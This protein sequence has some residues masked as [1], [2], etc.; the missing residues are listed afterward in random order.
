MEN[1]KS[2]TPHSCHEKRDFRLLF[3]FLLSK[4][5]SG[6]KKST[7][8]NGNSH[9]IRKRHFPKTENLSA[10]HELLS[11]E[12]ESFPHVDK[13]RDCKAGIFLRPADP[14]LIKRGSSTISDT[15]NTAEI[16]RLCQRSLRLIVR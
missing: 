5:P 14:G 13:K 16:F 12:F 15:R 8:E 2:E 11:R 9:G 6:D 7:F 10:V 1:A 4:D 3:Y